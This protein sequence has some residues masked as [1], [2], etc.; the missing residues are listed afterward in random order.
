MVPLRVGVM[1]CADIAWRAMIPAFIDCDEVSLV[2]VASR[3]EIKAEKFGAHFGCEGLVGYESLLSREDVEAIYMPL[4]T[5]LHEEWV[6]RTIESGKHILVEKSFAENFESAKSLVDLAREK[7]CLLIENFLFPHHSQHS[8]VMDK[9][10]NGEIG[11]VHLFRSTF[12]FPPLSET[13]FRYDP[14][15]GGGALLDAGAYVV[16]AAQIYLGNDL[17]ILGATLKYDEKTGVD[18]YGDVMLKNSIGQVAQLSFGFDYYYQC[19]YE[20][21]GTKGKLVVDRAF[22]PPPEFEPPVRLEHQDSRENI[23]LPADNH[24]LNMS[25]FFADTIRNTSRWDVHWD[26]LL[27]QA[28]LMDAIRREAS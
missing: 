26:S 28:E 15:L 6:K 8:W 16:K 13:N 12:G 24:Y 11:D 17:K 27:R 2:A 23:S 1:G 20:F 7:K 9:V 21:L 19:N 22:T 3:S 10:S 4:P 14:D 18:I 5:G 25:R